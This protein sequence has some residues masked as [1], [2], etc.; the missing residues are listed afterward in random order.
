MINSIKIMMMKMNTNRNLKNNKL[1]NR[2][3]LSRQRKCRLKNKNKKMSMRK[4]LIKFMMIIVRRRKFYSII[5]ITR[6]PDPIWKLSR[7]R[8]VIG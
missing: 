3:Q 2:K 8:L 6:I 7:K 1:W 5:R 4:N